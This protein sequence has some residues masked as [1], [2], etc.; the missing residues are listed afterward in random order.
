MHTDGWTRQLLRFGGGGAIT[1]TDVVAGYD[2][3]LLTPEMVCAWVEAQPRLGE[4]GRRLLRLEGDEALTFEARM[5]EACAEHLGRVPRP[6]ERSWAA[7]QDRWRKALLREALEADLTEPALARAI[8]AIYE[9]V[10]C[11]EDMLGLWERRSPWQGGPGRVEFAALW[12][13]LE[14]SVLPAPAAA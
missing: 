14:P 5:W 9:Q 11:P 8:E 10:G 4:A 12:T 3:G 1:W 13:F 7:A 2:F 6:G